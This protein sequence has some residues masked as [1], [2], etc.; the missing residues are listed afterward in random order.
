MLTSDFDM[1]AK[2]GATM[3]G[4]RFTRIFIF[5]RMWERKGNSTHYPQMRFERRKDEML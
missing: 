3:T 2:T 4:S 5:N 1:F